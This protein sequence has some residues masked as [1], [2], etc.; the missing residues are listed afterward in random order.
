MFSSLVSYRTRGKNGFSILPKGILCTYNPK[1]TKLSNFAQSYV[2]LKNSWVGNVTMRL[3]SVWAILMW[4]FWWTSVVLK[5]HS[6]LWLK[7]MFEGKVCCIT[8]VIAGFCSYVPFN[9]LSFKP[10]VFLEDLMTL[11]NGV[12]LVLGLGA[13][14]SGAGSIFAHLASASSWTSG[15]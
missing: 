8:Q 5:L 13:S 10:V 14:C 7:R 1:V 2:P 6:L 12:R 3:Q 4:G 11:I 9:P 15:T